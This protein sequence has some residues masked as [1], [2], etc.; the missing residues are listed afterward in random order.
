M[1]RFFLLITIVCFSSSILFAQVK[2]KHKG[3]RFNI[4]NFKKQKADYI[5]SEVGL[6]S[7]E[8]AAF[9][10]LM[11]ELLQKKFELN[12][13]V[14]K[15]SRNLKNKEGVTDEDYERYLN[16]TI[17]SGIEEAELNKEYYYKFTKIL[18]PRKIYKYKEA[19]TQFMKQT[20]N[21]ELKQK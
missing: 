4:E 3:K 10:P 13:K 17:S 18:S 16:L 9:I 14:R 8:A 12:R 20:I 2:P 11:D 6:S 7:S 19:E 1:K 5:V 21:K 15:E